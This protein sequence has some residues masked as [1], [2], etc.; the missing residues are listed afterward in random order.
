MLKIVKNSFLFLSPV[1]LAAC[2][3]Q[4]P[5]QPDE[6]LALVEQ[7]MATQA[8]QHQQIMA[9]HEQMVQ[10]LNRLNESLAQPLKVDAPIV[11]VIQDKPERCKPV[12]SPQAERKVVSEKK[13]QDKQIV[14]E[15]EQVWF[16][17]LDLV[18][19]GRI[20]TGATTASLDARDIQTFERDG[21]QWV[22]FGVM[23][24][25]TKEL[26]TYER[27]R[28]RKARVIQSNSDV[29][30][31]RSVVELQVVIGGI[32][33]TAEFTLSDR[34]HLD[35]QALIGRNVLRDVMLVDVS[36]MNIAPVD[37]AIKP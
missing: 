16:P 22:R 11:Q 25:A 8:A 18:L 6:S 27:K 34:S 21:D 15:I 29:P 2:F 36:K 7:C 32:A 37:K 1:A 20:D 13:Q 4:Q 9:H 10:T 28:V 17:Q 33:Q 23:N 35:Y 3:A 12:V 26:Q 24:P 14:G 31:N 30:E 19:P 5:V